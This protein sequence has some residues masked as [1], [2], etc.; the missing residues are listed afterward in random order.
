MPLPSIPQFTRYVLVVLALLA[1]ALFVGKIAN[2]LLLVF[3]GIVFAAVIRAASTPLRRRTGMSDT[4]SVALVSFAL[5]VLLIGGIYL[6]GKQVLTQ[7][8]EFWSAIQ[9]ASEKIQERVGESPLATSV[10]DN[11][12]A[13]T[14]GEETVSRVAKGTFTAFGGIADLILVI[15]LAM[16]LAADPATYRNGVLLLL[17]KDARERVGEA[18]DASGVALKKWL[19]GQLGAMLFVG[20]LTAIGLWIAGVPLAIPLG[21]LS[22]VLDFVPVV[23]PFIAAIPGVLIAFAQGPQVALYAVLVYVA[24]QFIEGHLVIP[25]AQKWAVS[26]PPALA[27]VAIVAF[28]VVFGL[29]GVLFAL[30]LTVVAMVMVKKLYVDRL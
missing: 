18:L 20:V 30:P 2:V 16:Y 14:G 17:P 7:T 9:T 21:I 3:A 6:F 22:G 10:L 19:V 5:A 13:A 11:M 8:E 15:F 24:V 4:W 1:L 26:M 29:P 23:G 12:K 27:L 28:G 25:L